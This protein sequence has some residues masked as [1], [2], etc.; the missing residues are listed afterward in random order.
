MN[1]TFTPPLRLRAGELVQV[2]TKEEILSTLDAKGRLDELPFMPEMLQHCGMTMRVSKRAHKTCDPA[3]GVGGR[4]MA[5]A[6]H[7]ENTRC[8]GSAHDGCDAG[9]LIFWKEAWLRRLGSEPATRSR[10]P[11]QNGG[12]FERVQ[13]TEDVLRSGGKIPAAAGES[14]PTYMGPNTQI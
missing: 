1:N 4:K 2:R 10:V 3:L 7:L 11:S 8:N 6:V 13:C 5:S 14:A 12:N 9:C